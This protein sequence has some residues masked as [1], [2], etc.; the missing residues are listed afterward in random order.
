MSKQDV[1][2]TEEAGARL[3]SVKNQEDAGIENAGYIQRV[4]SSTVHDIVSDAVGGLAARIPAKF[5]QEVFTRVGLGN[6]TPVKMKRVRMLGALQ[7]VTAAADAE[8]VRLG[9]YG[10]YV[11]EDGVWLGGLPPD[12][13]G[14]KAYDWWSYKH[15]NYD[16]T[17]SQFGG[18]NEADVLLTVIGGLRLAKDAHAAEVAA[19]DEGKEKAAASESDKF[20]TRMSNAIA[21]GQEAIDDPSKGTE[22]DRALLKAI[23]AQL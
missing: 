7:Q 14:K 18:L 17:L 2:S 13:A 23:A 19:S 9:T 11:D 16:N 5:G 15:Q 6:Y 10:G 20:H 12:S 1:V 8:N 22:E 4:K 3:D 21:T